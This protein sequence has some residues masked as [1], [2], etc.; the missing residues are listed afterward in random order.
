MSEEIPQ[1][2]ITEIEFCAMLGLSPRAMLDRRRKGETPPF[3]CVGKNQ[4]V[5]YLLS[6]A[7]K[8]K[9]TFVKHQGSKKVTK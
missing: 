6:D 9:E 4:T 1:E 7:L 2:S 3:Y 5:T 8:Y